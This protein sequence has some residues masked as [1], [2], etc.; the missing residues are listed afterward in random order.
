[1]E[2]TTEITLANFEP[3]VMEEGILVLDAWAPWCGP[4]R[5][6]GPIFD[7][8]A[9]KNPDVV[10]GKLNTQDEPDL[11]GG[12][13]IQ[14]IPTLMI[15]RDRVLVFRES[16]VL[17]ESA[18]TEL[19]QKVRELDMDAVRRDIAAQPEAAR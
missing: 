1:M 16:G 3:R 15:F 5:A 8:V 13:R 14:A 2:H 18:L 19:V 9:A 4:C 12:L 7:R 10:W 6:F 17:P 11:A